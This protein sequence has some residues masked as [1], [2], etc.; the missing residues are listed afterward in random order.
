MSNT[1]LSR[2]PRVGGLTLAA[3][4]LF[5]ATSFAAP[6]SSSGEYNDEGARVTQHGDLR[7]IVI[8]N[9]DD[10]DGDSLKPGG[11]NLFGA[12]NVGHANLITIRVSFVNQLIALSSDI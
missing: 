1:L 7:E 2:V 4:L 10:I 6:A 9:G 11:E 8:D 12:S 5:P 3:A